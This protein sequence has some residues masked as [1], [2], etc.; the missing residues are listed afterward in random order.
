M[1]IL[2]GDEVLD[3]AL[4]DAAVTADNDIGS[5]AIW[6]VGQVRQIV[7]TCGSLSNIGLSSI[8]GCIHVVRSHDPEGLSLEVGEGDLRVR[9]PIAP[10]LIQEVKVKDVRII[11]IGDRVAVLYSPSII[12][13]DGERQIRVR[14]DDSYAIRLSDQ[15]PRVLEVFD[16]LRIATELG[17]FRDQ[18]I[19]REGAIHD[20]EDGS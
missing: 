11:H 9:A 6:D 19:S 3:I 1:E 4:V 7:Q 2:K 14:G 5:K 17:L 20:I 8:G 13:L 12:A 16:V 10:G 15:G 18:F